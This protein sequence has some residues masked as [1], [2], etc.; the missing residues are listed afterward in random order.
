[1]PRKAAEQAWSKL[2]TYHDWYRHKYGD[3]R[4]CIHCSRPLP[5][6]EN[7]PDYACGLVYTYIEA[8]NS[9]K[10]GTWRWVEIAQDGERKNQREWLL[11]HGGWL[12]IVLGEGRAPKG[13]SAY[14][15]PFEDWV[16]LIEPFLIELKMASIRKE[17]KGKRPGADVFLDDYRLIWLTNQGWVI[18]KGHPWWRWMFHLAMNETRKIEANL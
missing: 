9:T 3:V 15:V 7:A 12:F 11:E 17:T 5:K 10:I 18:Q 13:K 1:M 8:K 2:C 16:D 4:Y 6:T 14:L